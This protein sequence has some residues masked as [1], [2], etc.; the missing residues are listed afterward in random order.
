M[1]VLVVEDDKTIADGLHYSLTSEGYEVFICE[2][3]QMALATIRQQRFDIYLLDLT[4]P[5]GSGYEVCEYI[6][7][8]QQAP[9]IFL[10]ACDDEI[11]VVRGLDM[12]A[13]D[14]ITKPFRI[15]E[16]I[17]RM[18][19]AL[20]HYTKSYASNDVVKVGNIVVNT[21]QAKVYKG[22]E[23]VVLTALEYRLLLTFLNNKGQVLTR[24][25]LL[26]G[27][28]DLDGSFINDNTLSVYIKRLRDKLED[29]NQNFKVIETVRG[30]GY[31]MGGNHD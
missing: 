8:N 27:I 1:K 20:K 4:L 12:G 2:N 29:S 23:E 10:T 6:K 26:E 21:K 22:I 5:D 9:V 17:S 14:Y 19:S 3:K 18:K 15:R 16:L 28:W 30:L 24:N 7:D 11:N 13:D 25:Q 31:R